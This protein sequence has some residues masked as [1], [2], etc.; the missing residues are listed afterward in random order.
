MEFLRHIL[1]GK[2]RAF[3]ATQ[4]HPVVCPQLEEFNFADLFEQAMSNEEAKQYLPDGCKARRFNKQF[5]CNVSG[6][7][8][9][10]RS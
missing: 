7:L 2:K 10:H 4:V 5:L 8:S 9:P 1:S 6:R 3:K